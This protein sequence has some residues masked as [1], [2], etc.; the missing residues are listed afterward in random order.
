T[1]GTQTG[2]TQTGDTQTGGT[3][4]GGTQTGGTQ[5][6]G[7]QTGATN[8]F[9]KQSY[10]DAINNARAVARSCGSYGDYN[11][12]PALSWNDNLYNAS[13]EHSKDMAETSNFSHTGSNTQSDLTAQALSLG[14]G[15]KLRDRIDYN[16]YLNWSNIGENIAAGNNTTEKTIAQWISSDGHCA[17]MM[18]PNFTE[19]GMSHAINNNSTYTD[20]WTQT[21]GARF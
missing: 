12:A 9:T 7:T 1:G 6:G 19:V 8:D 16:N 4:T 14:T 11:S 15:S 20:Y 5:T 21:F 17:N 13:L 3:Q 18:N 10:L 2:G